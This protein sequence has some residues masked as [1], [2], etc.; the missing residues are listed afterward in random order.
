MVLNLSNIIYLSLSDAK[1]DRRNDTALYNPFVLEELEVLDG[2]PPSWVDY[3]NKMVGGSRI[4]NNEVVIVKNPKYF[5]KLAAVMKSTDA[6]T[7]SNYLM[8]RAVKSK[9]SDLNHEAGTIREK[10]NK[11]VKGINS[12]PP[13]WKK[14]AKEVGFESYKDDSLR[15]IAS[16]MYIKKYFKS[17]AK[18]K[19][20][21]MIDNIKSTF[22]KI[23]E[24]VNWMDQLTKS[25]ALKKLQVMRNV[26]AYPD[27]LTNEDIVTKHHSGLVI[28]EGDFYGNKLRLSTWNRLFKHS[29]LRENVD[30]MDW[31]DNSLV[32]VVNAF[33]APEKN[34]MIFPAGI[35]Q[36]VFFNHQEYIH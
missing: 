29:R 21:E 6:R 7:V 26:I 36:G 30:K 18:A 1:E 24:E 34:A 13:R 15:V 28:K 22:K 8:W 27:E 25:K 31:R 4:P 20:I 19:M 9:M 16:S 35:L 33:Y 12:D 23:V 2:H 11:E 3:V 32:P 5:K 17:E 10:F 14:C